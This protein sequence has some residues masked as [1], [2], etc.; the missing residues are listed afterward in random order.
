MTNLP[1]EISASR[2]AELYRSRWTIET[3]FAGVEK[4]LS[5]EIATLGH[6][7]AALFGFGLAM[8]AANVLSAVQAAVR[9]SQPKS[10]VEVSD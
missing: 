4:T 6:P 5:G 9:A 3:A 2:V 1:G 7:R 8:V 10:N